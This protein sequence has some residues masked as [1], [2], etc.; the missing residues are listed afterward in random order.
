MAAESAETGS[1]QSQPPETGNSGFGP[2]RRRS[3]SEKRHAGPEL[4]QEFDVVST[5]GVSLLPVIEV[6]ESP[7]AF[8]DQ[9]PLDSGPTRLV[10]VLP[11]PLPE[12][13]PPAG[14]MPKAA[15]CPP[16]G[17]ADLLPDAPDDDVEDHCEL[18]VHQDFPKRRKVVSQRHVYK[19]LEEMPGWMRLFFGNMMP[20]FES[21]GLSR[22]NGGPRTTR[23]QVD[24]K[25][26]D[27]WD[28]HEDSD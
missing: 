18:H 17:S 15:G 14:S 5:E 21:H 26:S 24:F 2:E 9:V 28:L 3:L 8:P 6:P 22:T 1:Q 11:T 13:D 7:S 23:F 20:H 10:A 25:I 4:S 27:N 12:E 16:S 19:S